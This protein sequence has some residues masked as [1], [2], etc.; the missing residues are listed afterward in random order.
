MWLLVL[1]WVDATQGLQFPPHSATM[2]EVKDEVRFPEQ[3]HD[4][5]LDHFNTGDL[6]TFQQ[7]FYV[8]DLYFTNPDGPIFLYLSGE[9]NLFLKLAR[10]T[11]VLFCPTAPLYGPP[12]R[13]SHIDLLAQRHKALLIALEHR[14]GELWL[15]SSIPT[16]AAGTTDRA[17]LLTSLQHT[18]SNS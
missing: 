9:G 2:R 11:N 16:L 14:F 7:R 15:L 6:R 13:N 10:L 1:W 3:Y 4:Q 12:A 8:N 5:K 17:S 18:I